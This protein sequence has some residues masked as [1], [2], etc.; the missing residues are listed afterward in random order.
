MRLLILLTLCSPTTS[1]LLSLPMSHSVRD[2][3]VYRQAAVRGLAEE[4][5]TGEMY[6]TH[7][8]FSVKIAFEDEAGRMQEL[9]LL[10]DTGSSNL[11]VAVAECSTCGSGHTD[12]KLK[13]R[14]DVKI[15]VRPC[16]S[17]L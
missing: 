12:L 9:P 14:S 2:H 6:S 15:Q 1:Q 5:Y 3:K 7:G 13:L 16:T 11:A 17:E 8:D 4:P 10:V